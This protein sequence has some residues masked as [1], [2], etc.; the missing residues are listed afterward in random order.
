MPNLLI[1]N[2]YMEVVTPHHLAYDRPSS[3]FLAF[4]KKYYNLEDYLPQTNNFVV[5]K[6]YGL[7]HIDLGINSFQ[8][9]LI[10]SI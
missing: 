4:L 5:F 1:T 9:K 2:H 6:E 7:R 3:K 8:R 10:I